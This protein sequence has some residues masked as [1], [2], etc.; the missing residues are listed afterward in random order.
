MKGIRD[1]AFVHFR[2]PDLTRQAAFLRDFGFDVEERDDQLIGR[3]KNGF[4][5]AYLAE[6]GEPAFVGLAFEAES[7]DDLERIAAIDGAA[8][9]ANGCEGYEQAATL[10]DP[11]GFAVYV[12]CGP[13]PAAASP[14][15]ARAPINQYGEH[16]RRG[17]RVE[18]AERQHIVM[19]LG[20]CVL[21]VTN[22]RTSEAWYKDR[23][24]LLT[25]D[26]V[27]VENRD[28]PLGAFLRCNRGEEYVDHH[29][30]FLVG[31]GA[32]RFN[33]AAFEVDDWDSLMMG[34]DRLQQGEYEHR[35]GVG[36]H[37]LGSQ[38]FDYWKDP[39]GFTLEHFTDG[40]VFN[41]A[42]G[43]HIASVQDLMGQF[44]G[45]PGRP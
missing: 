45:P 4:P 11:D 22:F 20:H 29:T 3:G 27:Q 18:L 1:I 39:H 28:E 19:R 21:D 23:F 41:E 34:H 8:I 15:P 14:A 37:L 38:V 7:P 17:A 13:I 6:A 33:H 40:D 35:W 12:A 31:A 10:T 25:S 32:P 36:K 26:E 43:S 2:V 9:E 5:L 42:W 16:P 44:W 30:L 24:G